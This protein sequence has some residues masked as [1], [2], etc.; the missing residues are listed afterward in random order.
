MPLEH[1]LDDVAV[2]LREASAP[3]DACRRAVDAF[4]R[5]TP[6]LVAALLR[7]RDHLRCVAAT[8]SWQVL[9]S[10]PTNAGV[11]GRAYS[12]GR[13]SVVTR[14]AEDPD[15]VPLGPPTVVEIC[16]PVPGPDGK[17]VGAFNV[18]WT[19]WVDVPTWQ[20]IVEEVAAMLGDRVAELGGLPTESRTEQLLRHALAF[21]EATNEYELLVR[22]LDAARDVSGLAT[23]IILMAEGGDIRAYIDDQRPDRLAERVAGIS[24][25]ELKRMVARARAHGG[26]YSLGD[27][28]RLD[29]QGWELLTGTGVRSMISV[30]IGSRRDLRANSGGLLLVLDEQPTKIDASTVNLIQLLAAQAWTCLDRLRTLDRLHRRATSDPLTGL[31]HLRP[32]EQRL[33]GTLPDGTA[34]IAIDVDGFKLVNDTYGHQAGDQA[35][36]KLA[37]ALQAALRAEDEL[38]RIGGDEFAAIV[39]VDR[40]D[41]AVAIAERLVHAARRIGHTISV[42]VAIQRAGDSGAETLRRAD[43]ALYA[44]KRCGRDNVKLAN[45]LADVPVPAAP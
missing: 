1:V 23:P 44:A 43:E 29:D 42:G 20:V 41:E 18:E 28:A 19:H 27:P 40:P 24:Q 3:S 17:P 31:G 4:A 7:V 22:S 2:A 25:R 11:T 35:L 6:A 16:A 34:L 36:V 30:P 38:Y 14:V 33:A 10:L 32:F 8:G 37:R 5:H 13:T 15:Y 12:E 9:S 45:G 39:D 21:T 26:G